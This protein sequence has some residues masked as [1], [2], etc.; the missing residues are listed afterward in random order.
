[1]FSVIVLDSPDAPQFGLAVLE[2]LPWII[3]SCYR[4]W[5]LSLF[6]LTST[7]S[8]SNRFSAS[9]LLKPKLRI[10]L[11]TCFLFCCHSQQ[12]SHLCLTLTKRMCS[13]NLQTLCCSCVCRRKSCC[14]YHCSL[15]IITVSDYNSRSALTLYSL[16]NLSDQY[17]DRT[18]IRNVTTVELHYGN[19]IIKTSTFIY[20]RAL[21]ASLCLAATPPSH[22]HCVCVCVCVCVR[23]CVCEKMG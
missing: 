21:N 19:S 22:L 8:L 9:F 23:V 5:V 16:F 2:T 1:M 3:N 17:L 7:S 13:D 10:S 6:H 12:L 20:S 14:F 11:S 4:C 18:C 15:D